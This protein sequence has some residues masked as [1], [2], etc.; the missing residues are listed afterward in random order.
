MDELERV[1]AALESRAFRHRDERTQQEFE[2]FREVGNVREAVRLVKLGGRGQKAPW[3]VDTWDHVWTGETAEAA[4]EAVEL[5]Y[6]ADA[7]RALRRA[8]ELAEMR[9]GIKRAEHAWTNAY[10]AACVELQRRVEAGEPD[11]VLDVERE[12]L[13]DEWYGLTEEERERIEGVMR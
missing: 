2:R 1:K 8:E 12:R 9:F 4:L 10:A 3:V 6:R 11:D 13:A 7:A 5:R